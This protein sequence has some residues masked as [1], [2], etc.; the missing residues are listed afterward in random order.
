MSVAIAGLILEALVKYGPTVA[1]SI[2]D[3][4]KKTEITPEDWDKVF[5][6]AD[7]SYDEYVKPVG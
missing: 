5:A 3:I 6:L 4:F 2:N 7:K 1:R